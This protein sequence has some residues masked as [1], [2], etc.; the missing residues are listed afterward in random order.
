M[1]VYQPKGTDRYVYD[2]VRKGRRYL[3]PCDTTSLTEARRVERAKVA[4]VEAGFGPDDASDLTLDAA[5]A[6]WF[7]EFGQ[8]LKRPKNWE[9]SLDMLVLCAGARTRLRDIDSARISAAIVARRAIPAEFRSAAGVVTRPVKPAT[10]NRQII[11]MSRV[12]LRRAKYSWGAK[13][14][15][16]IDWSEITLGEGQVRHREIGDDELPKLKDAARRDYWDEFRTF[17]GT[18]GLRLGEMFFHPARVT[19]VDG[20]VTIAIRERKDGS[21]YTITLKPDDGRKML[22]RKSRAE[23]AGLE[24][25]WFREVH[26]RSRRKRPSLPPPQPKL[27][28]LTYSAARSALRRLIARSGVAD[29]RIHDFRHDVGTKLTRKAGIA[30]AQAQLGHSDIST[31]KRY[32]K[33]TGRDMVEGLMRLE[34]REDSRESPSAADNPE[35]KQSGM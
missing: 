10:I 9:R 19:V 8:Y 18:Y 21:T 22:A 16:D 25:V 3:G 27:E 15:H 30:V 4:E 13:H 35:R 1:S 5:A 6:R 2:F 20:L 31:T 23:I 24:T 34:S 28:P 26:K 29:F 32:S 12:I 17:L 33:V 11:E 14:L 7:D